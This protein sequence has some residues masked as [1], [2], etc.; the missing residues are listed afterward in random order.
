MI[1]NQN[2]FITADFY[3]VTGFLFMTSKT[4]SKYLTL[5]DPFKHLT[6]AS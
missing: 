6:L 4:M 5:F 3:K 2:E 1:V